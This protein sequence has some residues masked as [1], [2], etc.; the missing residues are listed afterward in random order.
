MVV[1]GTDSAND[2]MIRCLKR[3]EIQKQNKEWSS[4]N[5]RSSRVSDLDIILGTFFLS[6]L[7]ASQIRL[8][9]SIVG[10]NILTLFNN[11]C[12]VKSIEHLID[13]LAKISPY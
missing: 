7:F 3:K 4:Y 8:T 12:K 1:G 10:I 9:N 5:R 6:L 11:K 2:F 13:K